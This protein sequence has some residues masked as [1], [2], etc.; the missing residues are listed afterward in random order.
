MRE[1]ETEGGWLPCHSP[2]HMQ[3]LLG[4]SGRTRLRLLKD[5]QANI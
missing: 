1:C 5:K 3:G 2:L 4:G